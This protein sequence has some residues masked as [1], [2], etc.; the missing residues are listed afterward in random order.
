MIEKVYQDN[1]ST[2]YLFQDKYNQSRSKELFDAVQ[3]HFN[4]TSDI[5]EA[6]AVIVIGGDGTLLKVTRNPE[7]NK[8]PIL[9]LNGGTVGKNLIDITPE[10]IPALALSIRNKDCKFLE[11]PMIN[12][13]AHD[14]NGLKHEF[15]AFNDV[16]IDRYHAHT[17]KYQATINIRQEQLEIT[18]SPISGDG[19]LISTPVGST[20]Y[21]RVISEVILPLHQSTLLVCPM[22]SMV[23]ADKRKLHGFALAE[24]E[25]LDVNFIDTDF[26]PARIAIDGV[27]IKNSDNEH[28]FV[29]R[30]NFK[31]ANKENKITLIALSENDFIKKQMNFIAR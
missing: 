24:H 9:A 10:K 28:L 31:I 1:I 25:S 8:L 23:L 22:A 12:V 4:I 15:I 2:F 17:V 27:Y 16:F 13:E 21:A 3:E 20:G 14:E 7:L 11:F 29:E 18:D 30:A 5:N 26:R 19:I 6:N